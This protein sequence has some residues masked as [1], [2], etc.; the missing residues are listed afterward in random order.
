MNNYG[1]QLFTYLLEVCTQIK[2]LK[3]KHISVMMSHFSIRCYA[4][5]SLCIQKHPV[6]ITCMTYIIVIDISLNLINIL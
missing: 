5:L 3:I 4:F 2:S 6:N 1:I